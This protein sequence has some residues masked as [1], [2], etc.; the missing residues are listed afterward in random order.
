MVKVDDG[1][2]RT[3]FCMEQKITFE[4]DIF[5]AE[6]SQKKKK[7]QRFAGNALLAGTHILPIFT[8]ATFLQTF[9]LCVIIFSEINYIKEIDE[10]YSFLTM[11]SATLEKESYSSEKK[12]QSWHFL[13]PCPFRMR[14]A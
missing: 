10:C 6:E 7:R 12:N 9:T 2:N 14:I 3:L 13:G 4:V 8:T 1:T 5:A 11:V